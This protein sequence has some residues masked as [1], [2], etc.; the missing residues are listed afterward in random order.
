MKTIAESKEDY[1]L[2]LRSL[3]F[4]SNS[5]KDLFTTYPMLC[6]AIHRMHNLETLHLNI[7]YKVSPYLIYLLRRKNILHNPSVNDN[8][9]VCND[10]ESFTTVLPNLRHLYIH[11]STDLLQIM[12]ARKLMLL[13]L[14]VI[15]GNDSLPLLVSAATGGTNKN[16]TVTSLTITLHTEIEVNSIITSLLTIVFAFPEMKHLTIRTPTVNPLVS[17]S[18]QL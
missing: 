1:G 4:A 8:K 12:T 9:I 7:P 6:N 14:T 13:T 3:E 10:L 18:N 11:G 2:L 5:N 16:K 15:L 17:S